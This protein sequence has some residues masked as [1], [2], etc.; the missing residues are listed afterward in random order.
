M[1][2]TIV[3]ALIQAISLLSSTVIQG[4]I[5]SHGN[6]KSDG[7]EANSLD[8]VSTSLSNELT[9]AEAAE[10]L[11]W[12]IN[13][14]DTQ[15]AS[16]KRRINSTC[17]EAH[18]L[19]RDANEATATYGNNVQ[20]LMLFHGLASIFLQ[21]FYPYVA[22][23]VSVLVAL[24]FLSGNVVAFTVTSRKSER[25]SQWAKTLHWKEIELQNEVTSLRAKIEMITF[26]HE[27]KTS[28]SSGTYGQVYAL[29]LLSGH[30]VDF[31][32]TISQALE[33]SCSISSNQMKLVS[34]IAVGAIVYGL[35][36]PIIAYYLLYWLH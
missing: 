20:T 4:I 30:V 25:I 27:L 5:A 16:V 29:N 9:K 34:Q 15:Q 22:A 13:R 19:S 1:D 18:E 2:P 17:E 23:K 21:L 8:T 12:C 26:L 6:K 11:K 35:S 3:I 7:T 24:S 14:L 10:S 32:K 31:Q 36:F 33:M 28:N